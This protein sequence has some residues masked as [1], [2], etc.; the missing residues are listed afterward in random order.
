ML[1]DSLGTLDT[2]TNLLLHKTLAGM[3]QHELVAHRPHGIFSV[4]DETILSCTAVKVEQPFTNK[5][6]ASRWTDLL[7]SSQ[8][9]P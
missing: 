9:Y 4:S 1:T 6:K 8:F 2:T 5:Q 3:G 7:T